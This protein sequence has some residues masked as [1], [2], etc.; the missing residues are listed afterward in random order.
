MELVI[1]VG[2]KEER[3]GEKEIGSVSAFSLWFP[4]L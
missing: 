2:G 1:M 3:E 4:V